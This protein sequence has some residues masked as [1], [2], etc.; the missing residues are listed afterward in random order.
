MEPMNVAHL[1][2]DIKKKLEKK[3]DDETL[4]DQYAWWLIEAVAH[5]AKEQLILEQRLVLNDDQLAQLTDWLN[6]IINKSMPIQY[7]IGFV[8]FLSVELF[9]EPPTLIPRPETEEICANLINQ[10]IKLNNKKI[11]ILDI[12]TGS[13]CIALSLAKELPYATVYATD[14]ADKAL[15]LAARNAK[16]NELKNVIF[17]H[18][19]VFTNVPVNIFFDLIISNPPYISEKEW[20]E[21]DD[22]VAQWED[23]NALVSQNDGLALIER[24]VKQTPNFLQ[25]NKEMEQHNIPQL[26]LE[27]GYKQADAVSRLLENAG[28]DAIT[29]QKDLEGKDRSVTGRVKNV[30]I[31]SKEK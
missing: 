14:I 27:I 25:K 3:F 8:P 6:K 15:D 1:Q 10:L 20:E 5:R 18:S 19:N 23:R 30:A 2:H 13:G 21:L 29:I 9:V 7:A 28:F 16:H 12:G 4:C 11:T 22:S 24:I 17:L 31:R 26:I